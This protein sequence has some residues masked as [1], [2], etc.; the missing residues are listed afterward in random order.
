MAWLIFKTILKKTNATRF[1]ALL[2]FQLAR[3][4][5]FDKAAVRAMRDHVCGGRLGAQLLME[6]SGGNTWLCFRFLF[7]ATFGR[8]EK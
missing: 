2:R 7:I 3:N 8:T 6:K 1:F 5:S 4:V